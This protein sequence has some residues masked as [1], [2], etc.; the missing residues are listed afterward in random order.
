MVAAGLRRSAS[1]R[2]RHYL[3]RGGDEE[4]EEAEEEEEEE[5]EVEEEE[6]N[7]DDDDD[8]DDEEAKEWRSCSCTAQ[9][10]VCRNTSNRAC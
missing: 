7:D 2:S 8:D 1:V 10:L 9:L 3:V 4:G 5:E 6:D